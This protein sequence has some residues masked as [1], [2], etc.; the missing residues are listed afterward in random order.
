MIYIELS[1][2]NVEYSTEFPIEDIGDILY[3][4]EEM[5]RMKTQA[6]IEVDNY[7]LNRANEIHLKNNN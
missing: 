5:L 4:F 1:D 2:E 7:I 3:S 6:D